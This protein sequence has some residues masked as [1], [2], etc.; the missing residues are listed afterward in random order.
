MT[1]SQFQTVAA[2]A[3]EFMSH[4]K[5]RAWYE[6]NVD[7]EEGAPNIWFNLGL[8]GE[9]VARAEVDLCVDWSAHD[10]MG[11]MLELTEQI[12]LH[13]EKY[14]DFAADWGGVLLKILQGQSLKA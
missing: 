11:V 7:R 9:A 3:G 13:Y 10:Y 5:Y 6:A 8:I 4:P 2:V 12:Y 14:Q 1:G